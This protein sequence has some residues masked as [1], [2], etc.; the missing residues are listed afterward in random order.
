MLGRRLASCNGSMPP[1]L[2]CT[3]RRLIYAADEL[4]ATERRVAARRGALGEALGVELGL[5][6]KMTGV[7]A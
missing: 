2:C 1:E 5:K 4:P 3:L 7:E 6:Q